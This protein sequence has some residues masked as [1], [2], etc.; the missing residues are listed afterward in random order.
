MARITVREAA[1]AALAACLM[2]AMP[3][4]PVERN[5]RSLLNAGESP[6]LVLRDSSQVPRPDGVG[7]DH[8]VLQALLEGY[9]E[10]ADDTVGADLS[11]LYA[12]A[13]EALCT[14]PIIAADGVTEIYVTEGNLD[15]DIAAVAESEDPV[16]AFYLELS[17]EL[18]VPFGTRFIETP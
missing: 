10:S 15:I 13:S 1:Y 16:G 11:V 7:E 18:R 17:F 4:V 8:F 3:E 12:R 9:V 14:V 5:R 6:R 2:E